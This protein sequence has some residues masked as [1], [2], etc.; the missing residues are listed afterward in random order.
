MLRAALAMWRGPPLVDLADD[1]FARAEIARLDELR[2]T[3]LEERIDADLALGRHAEIV[4]ELEAL[5]AHHPLREGLRGQL[6]LALYRS[7]RQAGALRVYQDERRALAEQLGLEPGPDLRRLE[8]EILQHDPALAPPPDREPRHLTRRERRLPMALLALI[9]ALV[10]SALLVLRDDGSGV[11]DEGVAELTG[12][13]AGMLD[14]RTG[15]VRAMLPLGT[16]PSSVAIGGGSVWVLDAD[17]KTISRIDPDRRTRTRTFSISATPT[18]IA[19]GA[20]AIWVGH[21]FRSG[22]FVGTSYPESVSR[23]DPT[24][25]DIEATIVLP[26]GSGEDY[27]QGGGLN[28]Q[29]IAATRDAVWVVNPDQTVSR[30]DPRSNRRVARIDGVRAAD[31]AAGAD[32]VWV[33]SDGAVAEIDPRTNTVA[34]TIELAAESMTALAL[35][36]GAVWV[37]D[38]LGGSVWR[39]DP[40]VDH[41]LR[42]IP[43][44]LGVRSVAFGHG[45]LWATNEVDDAVY[46]IDPDTNVPRVVSRIVAPQHIAVGAGE[47]WVTALGAPTDDE[48]LPAACGSLASADGDPRLLIVSDLPL[49][50]RARSETRPMGAAIRFVLERRGYRAGAHTVGYRSCDVAT[51]QSGGTDIFRC[52]ANAKAYAR[53]L[54]VVGVIGSFHSMCSALLI[55][56]ANQATA[57]PLAM[58]S[59]S[60]TVTALTRSE[61]G[62]RPAQQLAHL[63]PTGERNFVRIAAA[64]HLSAVALVM[65]AQ[66][67]R[68]R[69]AFV[70]WDRED[71]YMAGYGARISRAVA[72]R[73]LEPAGA[74]GWDPE[75]RDFAALARRVAAARPD[76]VLL[77]G[78]PPRRAGRLIRDLRARLG[79]GPALIASDGFADFEALIAAAGRAARGMYVG[80]YGVPNSELPLAG[81]QFL[82]AFARAEHDPGPNFGAAYAAQATE[83]L[84]DAIARSDGTRASVNWELRRSRS[85][86]GILGDIRFDAN[87]DLVEAPV[88]IFRVGRTKAVVDRV[89]TVRSR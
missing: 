33:I 77:A 25:L 56:I 17:D 87:G 82:S 27:R 50:G 14:P 76:A 13:H 52:F 32:G 63:Y 62:V 75:A 20:D 85:E 54:D 46:R 16:A 11:A 34:R 49:Q 1:G 55:P 30:I 10:A 40:G 61:P 74:E 6:M 12:P 15:A 57:G 79:P 89:L 66:E 80:Y 18:D 72:D 70:L 7:G 29:R 19:Y 23:L 67:L 2:M 39:I 71:A 26:K 47:V 36:A 84:L 4:G 21:G 24:S 73:G 3:A 51:A 65:L 31:I 81:R 64:D 59:P 42:Q 78:A 45:A 38:A 69:R 43:L 8:R 83:L 9:L 60:N 5:V 68:R 44:A 35:G 48:T 53:K 88:T 41:V 58:I 28:Q 86:D 37:A 22:R